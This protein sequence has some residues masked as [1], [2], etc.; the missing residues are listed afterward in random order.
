VNW[1]YIFLGLALIAIGLTFLFAPLPPSWWPN[2]SR[3][4][5]QATFVGGLVILLAGLG[6]IA[7]G[8]G[9]VLKDRSLWPQTGMVLCAVGF[10]IFAI[11]Y[12]FAPPVSDEAT[13]S[14]SGLCRQSVMPNVMPPEGEIHWF[15]TRDFT[16]QHGGE[17][18]AGC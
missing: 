17:G 12:L 10:I 4:L 15:E 16:A 1:N 11:W 8:V 3:G 5:I 14:I 2:M 13:I 7:V 18:L 9:P 6:F